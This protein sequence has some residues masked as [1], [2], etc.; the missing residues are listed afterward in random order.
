MKN[1]TI[2]WILKLKSVE[3]MVRSVFENNTPNW[4]RSYFCIF[5]KKKSFFSKLSFRLNKERKNKRKKNL[6]LRT[7]FGLNVY[8]DNKHLAVIVLFACWSNLR[9]E[10]RSNSSGVVAAFISHHTTASFNKNA[11]TFYLKILNNMTTT[12]TTFTETKTTTKPTIKT[13]STNNVFKLILL[14]IV[15]LVNVVQ[16]QNS[17]NKE[18]GMDVFDWDHITGFWASEVVCLPA[19]IR[20]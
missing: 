11:F 3:S 14:L 7:V 20:F 18:V 19:R 1:V 16:S 5:S 17:V 15:F 13:A 8:L 2:V 4:S 6:F 9:D 12:V 10:I